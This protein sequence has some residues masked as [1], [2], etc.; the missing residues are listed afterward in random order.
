MILGTMLESGALRWTTVSQERLPG[1]CT[2]LTGGWQ[3]PSMTPARSWPTRP[4]RR[5]RPRR[6]AGGDTDPANRSD[7]SKHRRIPGKVRPR[8]INDDLRAVAELFAFI[9]ANQAETR[10]ILGL[11]RHR[12]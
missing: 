1:A 2:G 3:S 7:G 11:S 6:S 12:G 9:A 5:V 8:Q 4:R 10:R